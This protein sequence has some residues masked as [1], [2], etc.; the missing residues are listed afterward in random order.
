MFLGGR[1]W[2]V[3]YCFDTGALD[4]VIFDVFEWL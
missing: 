4:V 1:L 3:G 2:G